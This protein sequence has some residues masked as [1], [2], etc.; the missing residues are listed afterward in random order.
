MKELFQHRVTNSMLMWFDHYL[1]EKADAFIN[2]T[3]SFFY[4]D[5][6]SLPSTLKSFNSRYKQW[7]NDSS[8]TGASVPT[9]VFIDGSFSGRANNVIL[10]F[11]NGRVLVDSSVANTATI[12]GA[13]AVKD[14]N[15]YYSNDTEEDLIIEQRFMPNPN[16]PAA[17]QSIQ[18]GLSPYDQAI[19]AAFISNRGLNNRSFALGGLEESTVNFSAVVFAQSAYELDGILSVFADSKNEVIPD[20]PM[21]G[22]PSTEW[23]DV[24]ND[25]YSYTGV[26]NHYLQNGYFFV[27]S[28]GTSKLTDKARKGIESQL[29]IGFIDFE[30]QQHR[31]RHQ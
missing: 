23:G 29:Y 20:I 1:L 8:I 24:K 3:G 17:Q 2:R 26:H 16:L 10:D 22:H 28:V 14:I 13:F 25:S 12:T 5:D 4:E 19:P 9:G 11:E 7:V 31:Y 15:V 18:S 21:T 27:N 30:V 6:P